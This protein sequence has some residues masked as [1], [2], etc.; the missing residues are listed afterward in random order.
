M[1]IFSST[2]GPTYANWVLG[3]VDQVTRVDPDFHEGLREALK[4]DLDRRQAIPTIC[5]STRGAEEILTIAE[6]SVSARPR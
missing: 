3:Q 5:T 2:A 6:A 4:A 1:N